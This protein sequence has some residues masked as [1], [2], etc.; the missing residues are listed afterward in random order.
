MDYRNDLSLIILAKLTAVYRTV[1]HASLNS[2]HYWASCAPHDV[3]RLATVC[4]E[5]LFNSDSMFPL[6]LKSRTNKL[7]ISTDP[8]VQHLCVEEPMTSLSVTYN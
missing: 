6:Q 4:R 2:L 7:L 1:L 5:I 8:Q 3:F